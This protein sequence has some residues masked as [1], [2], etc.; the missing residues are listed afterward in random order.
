MHGKAGIRMFELLTTYKGNNISING[1]H[2][3]TLLD[4]IKDFSDYVGG[5]TI[6]LSPQLEPKNNPVKP[7]DNSEDKYIVSIKVK[8]YMTNYKSDFFLSKL[9]PQGP[10][11]Y[12]Y[13]IGYKID[14]TKGLVK[15]K[16]WG[17]M[18]EPRITTCM[19]CGRPLSNPYSQ[20]LGLGPECGAQEHLKL[21]ESGVSIKEVTEAFRKEL[22]AVT[23]EGWIP[24]SALENVLELPNY[25]LED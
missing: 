12:M 11:P 22:R 17:D 6:V 24:K 13:M 5:M 7:K 8:R 1:K 19:R 18:I 9:N 21:M 14:E 3:D 2:F 23:W 4:A 25:K 20:Y 16:C 10:M 15:M